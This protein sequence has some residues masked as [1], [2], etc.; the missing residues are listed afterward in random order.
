MESKRRGG[1][2]KE[3]GNNR[4]HREEVLIGARKARGGSEARNFR[5]RDTLRREKVPF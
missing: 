4:H 1:R 5:I 3:G 2:A